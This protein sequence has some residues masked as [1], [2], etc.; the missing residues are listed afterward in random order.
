MDGDDGAPLCHQR[1]QKLRRHPFAVDDESR[2]RGCPSRLL[3]ALQ[4]GGC[5][6]GQV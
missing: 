1:R 5:S 2:Q 6:L 4:E 3:V